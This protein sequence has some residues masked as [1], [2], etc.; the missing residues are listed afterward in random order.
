M[1]RRKVEQSLHNRDPKNH[2]EKSACAKHHPEQCGVANPK[3]REG[4]SC[5]GSV[6]Q[7]DDDEGHDKSREHQRAGG[8]GGMTGSRE[9]EDAQAGCQDA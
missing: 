8:F 6:D 3:H 7:D 1:K 4:G 9:Q 5:P 2:R